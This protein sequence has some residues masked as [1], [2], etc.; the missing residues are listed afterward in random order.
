MSEIGR[1]RIVILRSNRFCIHNYSHFRSD[2]V[3][4]PMHRNILPQPKHTE[5]IIDVHGDLHY[6]VVPPETAI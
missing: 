1:S 6:T 2:V 4:G 3:V 5:L